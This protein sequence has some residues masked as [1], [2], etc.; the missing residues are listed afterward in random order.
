MRHLCELSPGSTKVEPKQIKRK[1]QT[2]KDPDKSAMYG[3]ADLAERLGFKSVKISDLITKYSSHAGVQSQSR[4][5]KSTFVVDRPGEC[6]ERRCA[7]PFNLTYEQSKEYLFI[8][9]M[10][11]TDRSQG[12]SIHP[13]FVRRS[14]YLTYFGRLVSRDHDCES[15][16]SSPPAGEAHQSVTPASDRLLLIYSEPELDDKERENGDQNQDQDAMQD[17]VDQ[18]YTTQ[19]QVTTDKTQED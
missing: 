7:C 6:L 12:S 1:I 3:L 5:T 19:E 4:S 13:F 9:N 11:S 17:N 14:V 8:N 16:A 18:G 15:A 10:H 2:M